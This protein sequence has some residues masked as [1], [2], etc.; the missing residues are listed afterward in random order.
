[1]VLFNLA[2]RFPI[3]GAQ[4][5]ILMRD[6]SSAIGVIV[7]IEEYLSCLCDAG[8]IDWRQRLECQTAVVMCIGVGETHF[9]TLVTPIMH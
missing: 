1:M 8:V 6:E 4:L 5:K 3:L 2:N 9:Q 7:W